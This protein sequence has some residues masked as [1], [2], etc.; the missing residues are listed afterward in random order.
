MAK[1]DPI[2][3]KEN[4][5]ELIKLTIVSTSTYLSTHL[6]LRLVKNPLILF[7]TG[8]VAGFYLHKNRRQIIG[9]LIEAKQQSAQLL[10]KDK[11]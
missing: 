4:A 7:G 5:N 3:T 8:V 10:T 1:I 9:T 11:A 6:L 2:R